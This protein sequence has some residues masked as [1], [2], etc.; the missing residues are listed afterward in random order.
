M[1]RSPQQRPE[2][3]AAL[4][5]DGPTSLASGAVVAG[6]DIV[7]IPL[8]G[9]A[10]TTQTASS[11]SPGWPSGSTLAPMSRS[12]CL[13]MIVK[14]ESAVIR[15]CL[16]S[17]RPFIT[18]WVIVDTGSSDGT[19]QIV[20][21]HLKDLPGELF[22]RPWRDFGSN[23][24]EAIQLAGRRGD[25]LLFIDADEVLRPEPRFKLPDLDAD[26]Y[27]LRTVLGGFSYYRT[28]IVSTTLPWRW[29]GV[30]HEHLEC[31]R[32]FRQERLEGLV[33][34]PS[35]DGARSADPEK[36][37]KDAKVLEAALADDPT[38]TRYVFYLAQSH[39]DAGHYEAAAAGYDQ[40]AT[41]GGWDEEVYVARHEAA[42][43][44][45]LAGRPHAEVVEGYLAAYQAR[46][47]RA[48]SLCA[49]ARIYRVRSEFALAYLFAKEATAIRR[50]SDILFVDDP[51]YA[52]R[53]R[54]ERSVA[55]YYLGKHDEVVALANA[56]LSEGVLPPGEVER[57][58][59]N[60][61][62][63]LAARAKA[64]KPKARSHRR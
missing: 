58:K 21:E 7:K 20:R 19:Q 39:R 25:Y 9:G 6:A 46:P 57:V 51:V 26:A 30:L 54:D 45:E 37:A 40:R 52:W 10:P 55:A 16:D 8:A 59:N 23:R 48:E 63:S 15:R 32:P 34:H 2:A 43:M 60:R 4:G 24:T 17:V 36:Y 1:G 27:Q 31:D 12:L 62:L 53:A 38:N 18:S 44:R 22:E 50:P 3:V 13:N 35:P 11:I 29:V 56:L 28:Q 61:A 5:G 64:E 33:D 47:T 49:L 41:M 14:N 42:R